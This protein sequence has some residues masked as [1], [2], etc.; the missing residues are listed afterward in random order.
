MKELGSRWILQ[1]VFVD[2]S[3]EGELEEGEIFAKVSSEAEKKGG[4]ELSVIVE[5]SGSV[6]SEGVQVAN[7][8][9]VSVTE[10]RAPYRRRKTALKKVEERRLTELLSFLPLYLVKAGIV[11]RKVESEL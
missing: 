9:F 5:I 4:E 8:R 7:F 2:P 10:V 3:V 6:I 1:E 11:L